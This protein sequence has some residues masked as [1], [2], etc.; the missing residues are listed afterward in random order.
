MMLVILTFSISRLIWR[1][2]SISLVTQSIF[3]PETL[4]VEVEMLLEYFDPFEEYLTLPM[5][6]V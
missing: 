1:I 3:L 6:K 4:A 5:K 2:P